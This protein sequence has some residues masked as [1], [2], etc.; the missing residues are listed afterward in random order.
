MHGH[1]IEA[2]ITAERADRDFQPATGR[3]VSVV[4]PRGLR[5]DS[6]VETGSQIGLYYDSLL[7]K[8]IAHGATRQT[9]LSRLARACRR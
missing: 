5:F 3:I 2:R 8:L 7:A 6:G 1:A 4:P 9:A